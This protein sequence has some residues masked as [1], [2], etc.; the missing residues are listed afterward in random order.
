MLYVARDIIQ[1]HSNQILEC[2]D[3]VVDVPPVMIMLCVTF[4]GDIYTYIQLFSSQIN[5]SFFDRSLPKL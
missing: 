2:G 4:S 5:V 3:I 1:T